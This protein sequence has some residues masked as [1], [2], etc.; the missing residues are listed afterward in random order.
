MWS[1]WNAQTFQS[2]Y[3]LHHQGVLMKCWFSSTRLY[4]AV[5]QKAVILILSAL[6]AWKLTSIYNCLSSEVHLSYDWLVLHAWTFHTCVTFPKCIYPIN[7]KMT[8]VFIIFH[9]SLALFIV[10]VT[11]LLLHKK[12]LGGSCP[13]GRFKFLLLYNFC[14]H[15][16]FHKCMLFWEMT[17]TL[18]VVQEDICHDSTW[19]IFCHCS[20]SWTPESPCSNVKQHTYCCETHIDV[21]DITWQ[22]SY[23]Y[24]KSLNLKYSLFS[25]TN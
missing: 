18:S 16:V 11:N 24:I 23:E 4:S 10:A 17:S 9:T 8:A 1:C 20:L 25:V 3:Y 19:I 6:K 15:R 5:A 2:A 21:M 14:F 12:V 13:F 22:L 7:E